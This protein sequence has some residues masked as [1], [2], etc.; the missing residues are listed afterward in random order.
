MAQVLFLVYVAVVC[1]ISA[2]ERWVAL[3]DYHWHL[4]ATSLGVFRA[5]GCYWLLHLQVIYRHC[6]LSTWILN[7]V[8]RYTQ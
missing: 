7:G 5:A 8:M 4:E 3:N 2:K 6:G 1:E